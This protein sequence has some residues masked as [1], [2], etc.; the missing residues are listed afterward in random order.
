MATMVSQVGMH[1]WDWHP[2]SS[3]FGGRNF[4]ATVLIGF[5]DAFQSS[6][7]A[8]KKT[9]NVM[10]ILKFKKQKV[11][12]IHSYLYIYSCFSRSL[13]RHRVCFLS[14]YI[15]FVWLCLYLYLCLYAC[16]CAC[17]YLPI[18]YSYLKNQ[19]IYIFIFIY[20]ISVCVHVR[21]S[22]SK[23]M[24]I[25]MMLVLMLHTACKKNHLANKQPN[26]TT[27]CAKCVGALSK[28]Q[29]PHSSR[30]AWE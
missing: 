22:I 28:L 1:S 24:R 2:I 5:F 13:Y 7:Q 3:R 25:R 4:E 19:D 18:I 26:I 15:L 20:Y 11:I 21:V 12:F 10:C 6:A 9:M 8:L 14:V 23:V 30:L 29:R 16:M 17:V 27:K